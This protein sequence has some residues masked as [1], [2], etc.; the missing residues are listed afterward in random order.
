MQAF[1]G[2]K[3]G[4]GDWFLI[5]DTDRCDGCGRC[6]EACPADA[7]EAGEEGLDPL[8][9]K[10]VARVKEG[11]RKRIRYTCAP[12]QP[13]YGVDPTPCAAACQ[14]GVISHTETWRQSRAKK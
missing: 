8:Q 2:Y 9:E 12:C 10:R 7:L 6:V 11:E 13:G 3:D 5:I 4:A 1:Y 14:R